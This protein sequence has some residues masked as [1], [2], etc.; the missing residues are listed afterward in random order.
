M[1]GSRRS[2]SGRRNRGNSADMRDVAAQAGVSVA[3]V[4]RVLSGQGFVSD[5]LRARVLDAVERLRYTPSAVARSLSQHRTLT[6]GVLITDITNSFFTTLVR[7]IED[8]AISSGFNIVLCNSDEQLDKEK[9]YIRVLHEKRVDGILVVPSGPTIDHLVAVEAAGVPLVVVDRRVPGL[10]SPSILVDNRSGAREVTEYLLRLGHRRIAILVGLR[11]TTTADERLQ[12]YLDAIT[13]AGLEPDPS[14]IAGGTFHLEVGY[15]ST[16]E[17]LDLPEPPTAIFSSNNRLAIGALRALRERHVK[18][19][20]TMSLVSFDDIDTFA[21][22]DPPIT[23]VY[24]PAYE[25]GRRAAA[26]LLKILSTDSPAEA[27]GE[28]ET[29]PTRL[30]VR[31]S[32]GPPPGPEQS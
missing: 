23:A 16:L 27:G 6:I 19:P 30:I 20:K 15:H 32:C 12:G 1:L 29:H 24:Q 22:L 26:R 18:V 8:E 2:N 9:L 13:G 28:E 4:S 21:L 17:L 25:L 3:T 5:D 10:S 11:G 7:G 31:A 14:L